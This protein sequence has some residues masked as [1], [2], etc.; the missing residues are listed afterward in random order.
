[1]EGI[2]VLIFFS[3]L[4][5]ILLYKGMVEKRRTVENLRR[6]FKENFGKDN[7]RILKNEELEWISHY[8]KDRMTEHSIDELTWNDLDMD[9][10]YQQMAYTRSS[11][12]DDYLYYML[13][14]PVKEE[15]VL[16]DREKKISCLAENQELRIKLQIIFAQ[17]G[18]IRD[19]SFADYLNYLMQE[20]PRSNVKHY[21]VDS[22][23]V[24]SVFL[25][26]YNTGLGLITFFL[27]IL[28]NIVMYFKDKAYL[29]PY[30]I[31]LRY[32]FK[33]K[34]YAKEIVKW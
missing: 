16:L 6:G 9:L 2:I 32:L 4:F 1:M 14:N 24:V 8:C 3:I 19:Y 5:A 27:L 20:K 12:G 15:S 34:A 26:V 17:M 28:Y 31:S 25:M 29:E 18:R 13:R 11:P 22:L 33:I 10:I 23:I 21:L 30:L 7:A